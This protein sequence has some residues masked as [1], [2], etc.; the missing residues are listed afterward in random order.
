MG[1][2]L[3]T[4]PNLPSERGSSR[5]LGYWAILEA[6]SPGCMQARCSQSLET[7]DFVFSPWDHVLF[8]WDL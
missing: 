2:L 6:L 1:F 7:N 8:K 3:V 5:V 4:L